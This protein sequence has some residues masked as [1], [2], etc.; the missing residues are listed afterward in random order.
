MAAIAG[1]GGSCKVGAA[2][3][4]VTLVKSWSLDTTMNTADTTSLGSA[5][6]TGIA[7][8]YEWSGSI[9]CS[10][11]MTD[12][13]GQLAL[14]TAFLAGTIIAWQGLVDATKYYGGNIIITGMPVSVTVD[15]A[16]QVSFN[17]Q[18]TGAL[19]YT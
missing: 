10:F 6:K 19:T 8:V 4:T 7:T 9:E 15:D 18:G 14:Q 11:D 13:N 5:A 1:K 2:P 16:V 17:F 3:S 12:T